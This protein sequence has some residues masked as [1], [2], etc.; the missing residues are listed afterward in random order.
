MSVWKFGTLFVGGCGGQPML[1]FWILIDKTQMS[2]PP[3]CAATFF[4][5]WRSILVGHLGLQSVTYRVD[6]PCNT[7]YFVFSFLNWNRIW[8]YIYAKYKMPKKYVRSNITPTSIDFM[9]KICHKILK[10]SQLW[11]CYTN[12]NILCGK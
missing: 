4:K 8:D 9:F 2:R 5:T 1:L 10:N 3:E 11:P 7:L 12:S 6:T